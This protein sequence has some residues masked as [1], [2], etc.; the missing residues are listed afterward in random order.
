MVGSTLAYLS[1]T[2]PLRAD[3]VPP[4]PGAA[5]EGNAATDL[6]LLFASRLSHKSTWA[7]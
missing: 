3:S 5:E 1:V 2:W 4:R 6:A 7:L